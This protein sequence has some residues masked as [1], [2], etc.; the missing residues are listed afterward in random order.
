MNPDVKI[1]LPQEI[2]SF[3]QAV[4][5][6]PTR[7]GCLASCQASNTSCLSSATTDAAKTACARTLTTCNSA[8]PLNKN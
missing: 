3:L 2:K 4:G 5:Q 1:V 8:C 6:D 7:S